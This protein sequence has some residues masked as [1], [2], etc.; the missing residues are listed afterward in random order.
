MSVSISICSSRQARSQQRWRSAPERTAKPAD[1]SSDGGRRT[2]PARRWQSA[3]SRYRRRLLRRRPVRPPMLPREI[4]PLRAT[5]LGR[6]STRGGFRNAQD[7][8]VQG[9]DVA[10]RAARVIRCRAASS[11]PWANCLRT[12]ATVRSPHSRASAMRASSQPGP[13]ASALSRM[14]ACT[15][16]RAGCL[17]ERAIRSRS[18]RWS[19]VRRTTYLSFRGGSP[20]GPC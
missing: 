8:R 19:A 16:V 2:G 4:P 7:I 20:C 15:R 18:R 12:R 14:R 3:P 11:P 5:T 9:G 6:W 10:S 17:P 13:P 1:E